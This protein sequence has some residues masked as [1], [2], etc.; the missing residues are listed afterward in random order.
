MQLR[1]TVVP[2]VPRRPPDR[3]PGGGRVGAS[4]Q[5]PVNG[6]LLR[7]RTGMEPGRS[8]RFRCHR[9]CPGRALPRA[10]FRGL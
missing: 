7:S 1:Q 8:L 5:P 3:L 6:G 4:R 9:T 10:A 2:V